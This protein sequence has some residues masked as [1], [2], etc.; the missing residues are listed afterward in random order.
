MCRGKGEKM[1]AETVLC[2]LSFFSRS[3]KTKNANTASSYKHAETY[4]L[5]LISAV[6]SNPE[7]SSPAAVP[8]VLNF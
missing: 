4:C 7:S 6:G 1:A 8:A 3:N 2:S 5:S